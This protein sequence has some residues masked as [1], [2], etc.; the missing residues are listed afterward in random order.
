MRP[1][2]MLNRAYISL[3]SNMGDK[4][5]HIASALD[6]LNAIDGIHV[7]KR[8]HDYQTLPWGNTDQDWFVNACAALDT[9]LPPETLLSSC[10]EIETRMGRIRKGKWG[11]RVIDIDIIDYAGQK[12]E[13]DKLNL[14]HPYVLERAF[15]LIP[16]AEIASDL[17]I[18][19]Q[20]IGKLAQQLGDASISMI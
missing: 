10:L 20:N 17:V 16:L 19:G 1:E 5:A 7:V 13:S 8:S 2:A 15:V 18:S 9:L 3:G 4:K 12:M 6:H 14:P 11:P